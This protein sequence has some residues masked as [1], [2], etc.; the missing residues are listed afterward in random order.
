LA[1]WERKISHTAQIVGQLDAHL[2][3]SLGKVDLAIWQHCGV[4]ELRTWEA[5][6]I[7]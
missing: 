7:M 4:G 5:D 3:S 1:D 6:P 2:G